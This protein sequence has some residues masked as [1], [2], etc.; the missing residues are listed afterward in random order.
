MLLVIVD[1]SRIRRRREDSVE[2]PRQ[3][4]RAHV[5]VNHRRLAPTTSHTSELLQ[6]CQSVERVTTKELRSSLDGTAL[7]PVLVAPVRLELRLLRKLQVEVC[8][9][10]GRPRRTGEHDSQ[11]V[12]MFVVVDD[13]AESQELPRRLWCVPPPE[14]RR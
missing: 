1:Q 2:P 14:I 11:N 8:R 4:F 9:A 13:R 5:R 3:R 10:T 12:G 7:A 6:P